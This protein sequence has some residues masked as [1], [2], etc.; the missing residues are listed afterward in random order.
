MGRFPR[1]ATG[2]A[3]ALSLV[4]LGWGIR[5]GMPRPVERAGLQLDRLENFPVV[6]LGRSKPLDSVA[7][8]LRRSSGYER[9]RFGHDDRRR[10][11]PIAWVADAM[12]GGQEHRQVEL[13]RIDD[14]NLRNSLNLEPRA[15]FRYSLDEVAK[16]RQTL[17]QRA[18][19]AERRPAE[20]RSEFDRRSLDLF[21]LVLE[22]EEIEGWLELDASAEEGL[23]P[24][25]FWSV[26]PELARTDRP[27]TVPL[28]GG[29]PAWSGWATARFCQALVDRARET[30]V[31]QVSEMARRIV[32]DER[33]RCGTTNCGSASSAS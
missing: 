5:G 11:E 7:R 25:Y 13:F 10:I 28:A 1:L 8:S 29:E 17:E 19:E 2:F 30:D 32:A 20:R 33:R 24:L 16:G 14:P 18:R 22:C 3:V 21:Q 9:P 26:R 23:L 4:I 12:F 15:G 6:H 27:L 31:R